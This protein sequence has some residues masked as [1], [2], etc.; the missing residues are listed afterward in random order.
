M[1]VI[2]STTGHDPVGFMKQY[3]GFGFNDLEN[4]VWATKTERWA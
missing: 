2:Q 1:G 4:Q 3:Y